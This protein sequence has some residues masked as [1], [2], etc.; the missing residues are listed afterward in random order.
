MWRIE[1][2]SCK[3]CCKW[4]EEYVEP[5]PSRSTFDP[6]L[7]CCV[8][9]PR[10]RRA[11]MN[12]CRSDQTPAVGM[13]GR[14]GEAGQTQG[15][16]CCRRYNTQQEV[17]MTNMR[18]NGGGGGDIEPRPSGQAV[19]PSLVLGVQRQQLW[20]AVCATKHKLWGG[21]ASTGVTAL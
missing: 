7:V 13:W 20:T 21:G 17:S 6:S 18:R 11:I 1:E 12:G 5:R 19:D 9:P 8:E 15:S 4:C 2:V 10:R 14:R 16:L 3:G